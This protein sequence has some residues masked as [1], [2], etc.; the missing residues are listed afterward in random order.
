MQKFNEEMWKNENPSGG[1]ETRKSESDDKTAENLFT[2]E[3]LQPSYADLNKIFDNSDDNSNDVRLI[4]FYFFFPI[5]YLSILNL[6]CRQHTARFKQIIKSS[7]N[8]AL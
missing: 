1:K 7:G 2:S 4:K 3:G 8:G 5:L 6:A